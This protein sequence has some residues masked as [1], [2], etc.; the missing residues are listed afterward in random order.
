MHT[1]DGVADRFVSDVE[2]E[3]AII[4][5]DISKPVEGKVS[6]NLLTVHMILT[7]LLKIHHFVCCLFYYSF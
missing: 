4:M 3:L 5:K 7:I 2:E 6:D 1:A